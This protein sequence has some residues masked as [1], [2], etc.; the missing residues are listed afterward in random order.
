MLKQVY[1]RFI[2][3]YPKLVIAF[4][5]ILTALMGTQ[6]LKL[7]VD[8][9]AETLIL[10]DDVDLV[11]TRLINKRYRTTDYLVVT[12]SP[13][14]PLL[15]Q[16]IVTDLTQLSQEL[17][18]V[19]DVESITS[20]LNVP[21]LQ[22][23]PKPLTELLKDIPAI[24]KGGVDLQL[25]AE[26]FKA[27]PLYS[28]N[29]VNKD[30]S[31]TALLVN[32]KYD[33]K[34]YAMLDDINHLRDQKKRSKEEKLHLK[35][36]TNEFKAYRDILRMQMHQKIIDTRKIL[37]AHQA[38]AELFLGGAD[39]IADDMTGFVEHDLK[40]YGSIVLLL[41]IFVLY[42]VFRR[43]R[44][45]FLPVLVS[46]LSILM[47]IGF[48]GLNEWEITV[49]SSNFIALQLI[50]TISIIIHLIVRYIELAKESPQADQ[51]ELVLHTTLSMSKPTFFAVLTTIA[52]FASLMLS[53]I[54]P[55]SALGMMMSVGVSISLVTTYIIFPTTSMLMKRTQYNEAHESHYPYMQYIS[56]FIETRGKIIL[57]I[58]LLLVAFALSGRSKLFVENSFINYF[59][60]STEIYKGMLVIDKD[61]GGT[62]SLDVSIDL[63]PVEVDTAASS[64]EEEDD[65]FDEFDDELEAQSSQKQYWFT[66]ERME[67][68][69]KVHNYLESIEGVGKVISLNT[70]LEV[71]KTLNEGESLDNFELALL[72]KELPQEFA[73]IIL[74]PYIDI[75]N[76]QVRF[77]MRIIDSYPDL[78]RNDLIKEIKR[79][80]VED[81][82]IEA[83]HVHLSGMMVLYNNM[84]Q[85][86]F[87]SQVETLGAMGLLLF[88]MFIFLF[89]SIFV[90]LIAMVT[91]LIPIGIV[92]GFM[93]WFHIPL[94]MMTITIAAISMGIAVDNSI[95]YLYRFR[96]L[97]LLG[98]SYIESMHQAHESIGYAMVYTSATVIIGFLILLI[99]AFIPTIYF[100]LLTALTMFSSITLT[101]VLLP[102]ML[103]MFKPFKCETLDKPI[104]K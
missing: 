50:L 25:A 16:E 78:R 28:S 86:L 26:E 29:L 102:K 96:K 62:T 80:L 51:Y 46:A 71:G 18:E 82:N 40:T 60:P 15:S 17:L 53:D 14:K 95:H 43:I 101:L 34:F 59:K 41:L 24:N 39:M 93:G 52:G 63:P 54:K 22:S 13:F 66:S 3:R 5:L 76:N 68:I 6:A 88:V 11:Y 4:I 44:W 36:L 10:H 32:F 19:Q 98:N 61:L 56:D 73:N 75:E 55:I 84:L 69:S 74:K 77:A 90:A 33:H 23:P 91:N 94:D 70:L 104:L 103:I 64:D 89:R 35:S 45:V 31:T 67:V 58:T 38:H 85:S 79:A 21:L 48:M 81:Y 1:S 8:A 20:I 57:F 47:T 65:D 97:L 99:S 87:S 27:N 100:G 83:S 72:Y 12:Y 7:K 9:S 30:L 92:F 42:Y 2:L 37:N 49:I